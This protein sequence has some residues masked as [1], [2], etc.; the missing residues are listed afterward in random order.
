MGKPHVI[1]Q[2]F[3]LANRIKKNFNSETNMHQNAAAAQNF[4][5]FHQ[6]FLNVL[7]KLKKFLLQQKM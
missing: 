1:A 4:K 2:V 5:Y 6:L 7:K 3:L